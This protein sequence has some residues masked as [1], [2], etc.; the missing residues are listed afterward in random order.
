MDAERFIGLVAD[1]VGG[2]RKAAER[3]IGATLATLAERIERGEARQLAAIL[4]PPIAPSLA[5]DRAEAERFDVDEFLRRVA[6]REGVDTSTAERHA[7]AVLAVLGQAVPVK[8]LGDVA[9]QLPQDIR[10]L[11]PIGPG[12]EWVT[13]DA[14]VGRVAERTGLDADGARTAAQAVLETLAER[15][16]AGEVEDLRARLPAEFHRPLKQGV[17]LSG[18]Q[19]QPLPADE[20]VRRVARREGVPPMVAIEHARAV[21]TALR[22]AVGDDEMFDVLSELPNDYDA[23]TA[24]ARRERTSR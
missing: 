8:E 6:E 14:F 20:F 11:L 5:K 21:F 15:I 23:V 2:D 16:S 17:A 3:A 12:A 1:A 9:A 10:A 4:P 7:R 22:E 13:A 18:G 19:A 24:V